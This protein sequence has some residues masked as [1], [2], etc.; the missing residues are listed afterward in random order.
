MNKTQRY[1]SVKGDKT[2]PILIEDD[3]KSTAAVSQKPTKVKLKIADNYKAENSILKVHS[4][5]IVK[6][7]SE[8]KSKK[9]LR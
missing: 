2:S 1:S 5:K 4:R 7:R 3:E 6:D 8:S 9:S